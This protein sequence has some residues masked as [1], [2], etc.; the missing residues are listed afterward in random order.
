MD[1]V[2]VWRVDWQ[3]RL[4]LGHGVWIN[5]GA[6]PAE[7]LFSV[8]PDIGPENAGA[9]DTMDSTAPLGDEL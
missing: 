3:Q 5:D 6:I 4:W 1:N 8:A 7:V 9:Y 2:E